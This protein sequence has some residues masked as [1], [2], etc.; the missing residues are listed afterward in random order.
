MFTP[1]LGSVQL[2]NQIVEFRTEYQQIQ[3]QIRN[4]NPRALSLARFEPLSL[5]DVQ[6]ELRHD[7]V[8]L[9][10]SLGD[11][12]SYLWMVTRESVQA[13]QLPARKTI[14]D[15]SVE[16]YK[17]VTGQQ[18]LRQAATAATQFQ[19]EESERLWI[20]KASELSR[21][22]FGQV[23]TQLGSQRLLLVTEGKLQLVPFDALLS[24]LPEI[25]SN[26][27]VKPLILD[28]EIVELPSIATLRA[29]RAAENK[30]RDAADKI[31]AVIAD[32]V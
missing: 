16:V 5:Q 32:P 6:N 17:S 30:D 10:F 4:Q 1:Q 14:E 12:R 20:P 21:M 22:L 9:E 25:D 2:E 3:A 18:H 29:I 11:E 15:L 24:P 28:H 31:A 8:L 27:P 13:F 19:V 7:D 23:A 26:A